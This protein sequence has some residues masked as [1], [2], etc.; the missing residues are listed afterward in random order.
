MDNDFLVYKIDTFF[1]QSGSAVIV[2]YKNGIDAIIGVHIKGLTDIKKN[3][4][5]RL[6]VGK[7]QQANDMMRI[8]F[9]GK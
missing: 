3:L 2:H 6:T 5:N 7:M 4:A 1:G 8:S 9:Q